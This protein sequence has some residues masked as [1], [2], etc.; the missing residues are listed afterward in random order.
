MLEQ[1]S[2]VLSEQQEN[3]EIHIGFGLYDKSGTYSVWVGVT[4]QSII[5][6]TTSMVC[7]HIV[8]DSTLN[9]ENRSK[10]TQ[11][12][13]AG[14]HRICFHSIDS[15]IVEIPAEQLHRFTIGTLFRVFL[16]E[17]LPDISK[18][19]YLDA[20][21]Y[22]NR[23]IR[24]LWDMDI[25]EY[26][27]IAVRDMTSEKFAPA[28]HMVKDGLVDVKRYF[29]AGVLCINLERVRAEG[30]MRE[31]VLDFIINTP[32]AIWFDQDALNVLYNDQTLLVDYS[33]NYFTCFVTKDEKLEPRI[34]HYAGERYRLFQERELTYKY[35][36]TICHTP[37]GSDEIRNQITNLVGRDNDRINQ[38][39]MLTK[40]LAKENVK[41]IFYGI[42]KNSM[43]NLFEIVGV[44]EDSY[45]VLADMSKDVPGKLQ[46]KQLETLNDEK[47]GEFIVFVL[48]EADES[49][50]MERLNKMGLKN[51]EDYFVIPRLMKP[52]Q[53]G[54][55]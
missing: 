24:E 51:S 43:R 47:K 13:V 48:P 49:T 27:L 46:C 10:L 37:W 45:R 14:G 39:Q 53:G 5:E 50:A 16:P 34:Y 40:Q 15:K 29:N 36:E 4:M 9:D 44:K 19:I 11:V 30:N 33:W 54:Y 35:L 42:E 1:K 31:K 25:D 20:D 23:D 3:D 28:S 21:V 38:W 7:F 32:K 26:M 22:V 55:I 17:L 18:V 2:G 52:E 8:H 41:K 12:A 6:N